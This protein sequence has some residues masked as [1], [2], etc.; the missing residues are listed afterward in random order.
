MDPVTPNPVPPER[1]FEVPPMTPPARQPL[2][3]KQGAGRRRKVAAIVTFLILVGVLLLSAVG[4][5]LYLSGK[6]NEPKATLP[7]PP[8]PP[9]VYKTPRVVVQFFATGLPN[10]TDIASNGVKDD[11]N[12]YVTDRAGLIRVVKQ[13]GTVDKTPYLDISSLVLNDGEMGLLSLVFSPTYQSDGYFYV[14]YIDKAQQTVIARYTAT[15]DHKAGDP[16]TAQIIMTIKQP[17]P[18]HKAGDLAFGDDGYL[19][20]PTGDGGSA[21]DPENRAQN[22]ADFLGKILRIDVKTLPYKVPPTNPYA[23]NK[24]KKQAPEVWAYGLRNP[25]RISFDRKTNELYIADVGQD[26]VEEVNVE[27]A[28]HKGGTNYGWRC[29]EGTKEYKVAGCGA[30]SQYVFPVFEYPHVGDKCSGSITGGYVYRGEEYPAIQ[31]KYFYADYC[32]GKVYYAEKKDGA[33]KQT[34]VATTP[35]NIGTFGEANNGE[36]YA[37]DFSTG[38]IFRLRDLAN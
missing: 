30:L 36:L 2:P 14:N 9:V 18:N 33:W 19:Y 5:A 25:W 11:T 23:K 12:L 21:G 29:Y 17:Y 28:G 35:F 10:P 27:P 38:S 20:I 34:D 3:P 15:P 8:P 7:P 16:A 37:A 1:P 32:S 24:N 6:K 4:G 22:Q 13:D 26:M 31:G